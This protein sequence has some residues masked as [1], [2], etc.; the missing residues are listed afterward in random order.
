MERS[1]CFRQVSGGISA[2]SVFG[3]EINAVPRFQAMELILDLRAHA[4]D[5]IRA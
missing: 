5:L 1:C 4:F 3:G 2:V